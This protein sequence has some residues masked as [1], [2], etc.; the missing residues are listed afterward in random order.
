MFCADDL[1][2]D[3]S[4]FDIL[5]SEGDRLELGELEMEIIET[6]GHTAA[7]VSY[8]AGDAVSS[9]TR[10]SCPTTGPPERTSPA[11]MRAQLYRSIHKLWSY[12]P[13]R[14]FSCAMTIRRRVATNIA[15]RR[16]S[17]RSG[18]TCT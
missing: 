5:L 7:D 4:D 3:G 6:P 10:S 1:K 17:R 15:G 11:A 8:K 14:A 9:A 18:E 2:V 13:K 16:R 12:P